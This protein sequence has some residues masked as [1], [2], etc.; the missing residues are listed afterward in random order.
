MVHIRATEGGAWRIED[1]VEGDATQ[2]VLSYVRFDPKGTFSGLSPT[3]LR[4][5]GRRR[6]PDRSRR[7]SGPAS[8]STAPELAGIRLILD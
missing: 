2:D 8:L 4:E 3:R 1:Y 5:S 7:E 6:G